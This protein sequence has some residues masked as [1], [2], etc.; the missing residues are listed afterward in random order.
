[1]SKFEG[2]LLEEGMADGYSEAISDLVT[3]EKRETWDVPHS[4]PWQP[5]KWTAVFL[6]GSRSKVNNV[7]EIL[8]RYIQPRWYLN[9]STDSTEYV[10]FHNKVFSYAKGDINGLIEAQ[11]YALNAGVPKGQIDWAEGGIV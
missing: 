5:N 2:L 6:S 11:K 3:E 9:L 10:V 7:A 8:S 4:E 1:M